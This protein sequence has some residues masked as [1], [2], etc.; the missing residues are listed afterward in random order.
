LKAQVRWVKDGQAGIRFL[1][2]GNVLNDRRARIG[3]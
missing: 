3:V 1:H 2:D